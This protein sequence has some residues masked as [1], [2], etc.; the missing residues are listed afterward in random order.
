MTIVEFALPVGCGQFRQ[1]SARGLLDKPRGGI[2]ET[3]TLRQGGGLLKILPLRCTLVH[4][5]KA[6]TKAVFGIHSAA[7]F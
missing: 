2:E 4:H 6:R 5:R 7:S 3:A 1:P